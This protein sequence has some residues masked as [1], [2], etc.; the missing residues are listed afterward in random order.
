MVKDTVASDFRGTWQFVR[1]LTIE[2]IQTAPADAWLARPHD[3][4]G[5]LGQQFRHV[6]QVTDLYRSG[7]EARQLVPEA[8][9]GTYSGSLER[10]DLLEGI[11]RAD[12]DFDEALSLFVAS[13]HD[14]IQLG[15]Q[16]MSL[17][18]FLD[19][20]VEHEAM[21]HGLWSVYAAHA[22]FVTPRS[23]RE[24]WDL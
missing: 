5:T 1:A 14:L 22:G 21:H 19:V 3:R 7:L 10:A 11:A 18:G 15:G 8:K 2:F 24:I 17:G 9:M 6:V 23:W 4:Y 20:C 12:R 13:E 16:P